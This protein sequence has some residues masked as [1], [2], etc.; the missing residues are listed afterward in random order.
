[1][2]QSRDRLMNTI[3][4]RVLID[5]EYPADHVLLLMKHFYGLPDA[6]DSWHA[7]FRRY[8]I[9]HSHLTNTTVDPALYY[10]FNNNNLQESTATYVDDTLNIGHDLFLKR[11]DLV[12]SQFNSRELE[13]DNLLFAG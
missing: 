8:M 7:T 2:F 3:A 11:T 12:T 4:L 9:D 13:F 5:L 6:G 10:A 1:M